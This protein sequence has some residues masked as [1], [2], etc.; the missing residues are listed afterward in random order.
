MLKKQTVWLLTM[1]SLMI[2]L[3]V[4]YM[5]SPN[6]GEIAYLDQETEGDDQ[7]AATD[8]V[9]EGE[10]LD[11][12]EETEETLEMDSE[13][14][15]VTSSISTDELFTSTRMKIEDERS[16][17][18][19]QLDDIV[20]SSVAS[21]EEVNAAYDEIKELDSLSTKELILE[22]DI[23]AEKGYPDVLVRTKDNEV[24]VT[25]KSDELSDT[26]ANHIMQMAKDEFGEIYVEVKFQP[27]S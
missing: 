19:E 17:R 26:D 4:Y 24:V 12:T 2:V 9:E 10:N 18:I 23:K 15:T 20:A 14:G 13:E 8:L 11:A 5:S 22:D 7:T 27:V 16:R 25:V 6:G 3:S 1:L 21:T